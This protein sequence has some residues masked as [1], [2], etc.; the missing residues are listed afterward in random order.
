LLAGGVITLALAGVMAAIEGLRR[1]MNRLARALPSDAGGVVQAE[2]PAMSR[3]ASAEVVAV[4]AGTAVAAS[5][6]A[7]DDLAAADADKEAVEAD[8][9]GETVA[10]APSSESSRQI[11]VS[12]RPDEADEA[13][14]V[15]EAADE[16]EAAP[17]EA[18]AEAPEA[19]A[20]AEDLADETGAEEEDEAEA[21]AG[22]ELYVVEE[23]MIR[24][25][26]ARMLSDGTVEAETDE[27]WMRF[28]NLEH[29]EEYMEAMTPAR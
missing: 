11:F 12:P 19:D 6:A 7:E 1:Q 29:L 3:E 27:G 16:D 10:E 14:D 23:R 8:A 28:E 9:D 21:V 4:I 26:P 22:D 5:V 17:H 13:D 15:A 18:V 20:E 2:S 25:R 24:G